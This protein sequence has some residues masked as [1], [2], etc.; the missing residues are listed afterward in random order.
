MEDRTCDWVV[1]LRGYLESSGDHDLVRELWPTLARL[2]D[3]YRQ[4]LTPRGLVL[5]RE[6][7]VW[8]NALRYQICEGTGLNAMVYRAFVDASV[9]AGSI[10]RKHEARALA[11]ESHQL[12]SAFDQLLWNEGAGAYDGALFGPGSVLGH[13]FTGP[14]VDGRFHPTAQANLFALY[15]GVVP[16]ERLAR[17]RKWVLNH[18]DEVSEPMSHYYLF[19]MLYAM[20]DEQR[21]KQT[22]ELMRVGWENQVDSEWQTTWEELEKG[23]GSKV[24]I[25]G[26]HP[27]YF[28]TA[29]VLGARREG[30]VDQRTILVEPRFSG[31]DWARGVCVT[32]FGPVDIEWTMNG[33]RDPEIACTIPGNVRARLRLRSQDTGGVLEIDGRVVSPHRANGWLEAP[34]QPGKHRIRVSPLKHRPT[35]S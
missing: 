27:G 2:L 23:G 29:F 19:Q 14:V 9:L 15:S 26:M 22:L 7:E 8:D 28:L 6:W 30:P 12:Q 5:A 24:H 17:V 11:R 35:S 4:R 25:Y 13:K 1:Q 33:T 16:R 31:L 10:G 18:L 32:E 3:W 34:L 21:D 20:E